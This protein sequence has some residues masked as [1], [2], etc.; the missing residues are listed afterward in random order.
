MDG[1]W[2]SAIDYDGIEQ[3]VVTNLPI[4]HRSSHMIKR[5]V[6]GPTERAYSKSNLHFFPQV[7]SSRTIDT[8][9]SC[10]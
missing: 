9:S 4:F 1:I 10:V 2:Q 6:F 3:K 7:V 5:F 8:R